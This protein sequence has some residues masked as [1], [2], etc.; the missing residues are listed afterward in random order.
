MDAL[1]LGLLHGLVDGLV[2]DVRVHGVLLRDGVGHQH[3]AAQAHILLDIKGF[4]QLRRGVDLIVHGKA[5]LPGVEGGQL[6]GA[7]ADDGHAVGLQVLQ[8]QPQVQNGLGA[9][10]DHHHGGVGQLLQIGG[11]VHG[12][13]S[14]PVHAADAAGGEHGD[15][16]HVGD[17]HGSG[18]SGGAVP[19]L[20]H[21][22]GQIPTAGLGH[23]R[24]GL[25]QVVDLLGREA[26]LQP[27]ADDG[28]GGRGGAVFPDDLLH[29][30]GRLH[31]LGIGHAVGDDGGFQ[32]HHGTTL[33][34]GLL[35]FRGDVEI[36]VQ[37]HDKNLQI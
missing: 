11:D 16:G 25:A 3:A 14:P 8:G 31:I 27:P 36:L 7:V 10:T 1:S 33:V 18:D 24:A 19:A 15:P 12:G 34:Q 4:G 5:A 22:H 2:D 29:V 13:L 6:A 28:D 35:H 32:C 9:G 17:N 21:Q 37:S 30:Q 23:G 26:G 20:R